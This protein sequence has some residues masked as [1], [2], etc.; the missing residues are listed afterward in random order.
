M[1]GDHEV[2]E[3]HKRRPSQNVKIRKT[4]G[5]SSRGPEECL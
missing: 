1:V 3:R 4:Q 5:S 2:P